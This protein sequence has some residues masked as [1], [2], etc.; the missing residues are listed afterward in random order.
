MDIELRPPKR[1]RET[2][3]HNRQYGDD[4]LSSPTLKLTGHKGSVYALSYSPDGSSLISASFDMTCLLWDAC[5]KCNNINTLKGHSNAILDAK[6]SS[7]SLNIV[8][9]SADKTL[10]L[11]DTC[12]G[13]LIKR[14]KGHESIVNALHLPLFKKDL[15]VSVSD[16]TNAKIWDTRLRHC[17]E[18]LKHDFP[19]LS[20]V[21]GH[22]GHQIFTSG[23]E[24]VIQE[25]DL[26]YPKKLTSM[27]GH[28]DIIT[29]LSIHPKGT[30]LL[31]NSMD[32]TLKTWNIQPFVVG[33]QRLCKTFDGVTHSAEQRLLHCSWNKSGTMVTGGSADHLVHIWDEFSTEELYSLTGHSGSVNSVVF[34]PN[35]SIVA[36]ASSDNSIIVGKLS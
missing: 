16:D 27:T 21:A 23:I 8:T 35:E 29:G 11:F 15:L 18:T 3:T 6:W 34:H 17:V 22:E 2:F 20:T 4:V 14:F 24:P 36:S 1:I 12:T 28:D 7:D 13:K 32:G 9:A 5:G 25:W 30:H 10:G 31:S 19:C 33:N 26:R